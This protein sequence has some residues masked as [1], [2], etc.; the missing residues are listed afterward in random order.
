MVQFHILTGTEAVDAPPVVRRISFAD[1]RQ[2]L[3]KG[4]EDFMAMPSHA[5]FLCLI[6]PVVGIL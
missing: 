4:F 3:T 5:V 6:Y 2:A 1:L